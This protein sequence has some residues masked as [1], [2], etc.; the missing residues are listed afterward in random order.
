M[1]QRK[2]LVKQL[3]EE[4]ETASFDQKSD[5]GLDIDVIEDYVKHEIQ[6]LVMKMKEIKD[7]IISFKNVEREFDNDPFTAAGD[8]EELVR[9]DQL[10]KNDVKFQQSLRKVLAH[11]GS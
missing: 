9:N 11:F 1:A 4:L 10:A 2:E 3:K 7:R 5:I 8:L 6:D